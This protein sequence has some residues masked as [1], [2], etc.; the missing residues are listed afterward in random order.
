MLSYGLLLNVPS[1]QLT[2]EL[3]DMKTFP[4]PYSQWALWGLITALDFSDQNNIVLSQCL[5]VY[6]QHDTVC[7]VA[8]LTAAACYSA[9]YGCKLY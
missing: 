5:Q 8:L 3:S 2:I 1:V 9:R 7:T 6:G 4:F